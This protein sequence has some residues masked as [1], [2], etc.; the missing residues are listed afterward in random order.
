[1]FTRAL[2]IITKT[3]KQSRCPSIVEWINRGISTDKDKDVLLRIMCYSARTR[4]QLSG[5]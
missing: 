3:W 2:F 5:H 1:M 4:N